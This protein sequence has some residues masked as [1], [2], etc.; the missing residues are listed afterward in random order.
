MNNPLQESNPGTLPRKVEKN[1]GAGTLPK[2]ATGDVTSQNTATINQLR[3][4]IKD[5][6]GGNPAPES[7]DA[8]EKK[9]PNDSFI[10]VAETSG[11][12]TLYFL[13][14]Y[15]CLDPKE[16]AEK[17]KSGHGRDTEVVSDSPK[18]N[19]P[20]QKID[21]ILRRYI[22]DEKKIED[23]IRDARLVPKRDSP[24]GVGGLIVGNVLFVLTTPGRDNK[25]IPTTNI[26]DA[27]YFDGNSHPTLLEWIRTKE[28]KYASA[29]N[30]LDNGLR[31]HFLGFGLQ[32]GG[33][34]GGVVLRVASGLNNQTGKIA[35]RTAPPKETIPGTVRDVRDM[36]KEHAAYP[37]MKL[38]TAFKY[39]SVTVTRSK[40]ED[41]KTAKTLYL[42]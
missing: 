29:K 1:D 33:E 41:T 35:D 31:S 5:G 36:P 15:G 28:G 38:G 4:I 6:T 13:P 27:R 42:K 2:A 16:L 10:G 32:P 39:S 14:C 8:W 12:K 34:A 17:L 9:D 24:S 30:H 25:S 20:A 19:T 7:M 3:E 22:G 40:R 21:D 18:D 23:A 37:A 11:A 26:R